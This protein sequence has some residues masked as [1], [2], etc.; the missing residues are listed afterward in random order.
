MTTQALFSN[1]C[2]DDRTVTANSFAYLCST[3]GWEVF[4]NERFLRFR[5]WFVYKPSIPQPILLNPFIDDRTVASDSSTYLCSANG[6]KVFSDKILFRFRKWFSSKPITA[7]TCLL[8]PTIY[9]RFTSAKSSRNF[10]PTEG[11]EVFPDES[12]LGFRKLV[13]RPSFRGRILRVFNMGSFTKV[14]RI[15]ASRVITTVHQN[16]TLFDR[17]TVVQSKCDPVSAYRLITKSIQTIATSVYRP[18]PFPTQIVA[19]SDID[20][21]PKPRSVKVF[22]RRIMKN[23]CK[24]GHIIERIHMKPICPTIQF[25][26]PFFGGKA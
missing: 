5:E 14:M 1:P 8:N 3:K 4:R 2:I 9:C 22:F 13:G 26:Q 18:R 21:P 6:R 11:W 20:I 17:A 19:V 16:L 23:L 25:S 7:Q 15:A 10:N 24:R 12:F